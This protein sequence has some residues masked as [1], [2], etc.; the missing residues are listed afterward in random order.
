MPSPQPWIRDGVSSQIMEAYAA[1]MRKRLTT[2]L[3]HSVLCIG[4]VAIPLSIAMAEKAPDAAPPQPDNPAAV[5]PAVEAP[6]SGT[7]ENPYKLIPIRNPFGL[8]APPPPSTDEAPPPPPPPP[9]ITVKLSGLTDL[10]GR[11]IAMLVL[12]ESGPNKT[13]RSRQLGEGEKES[14]VEV[15]AIDFSSRSVK[16]NNNGQVTNVTFGKLE[17]SGA[18]PPPPQ[19]AGGTRVLPNFQ[20]GANQVPPP[21]PGGGSAS[22]NDGNNSSVIIGGQGGGDAGGRGGARGGGVF[23][24]GA[25]PSA[26]VAPVSSSSY[27]SPGSISSPSSAGSYGNTYNGGSVGGGGG[28]AVLPTREPRV[29]SSGQPRTGTPRFQIP[30]PPP[31]PDPSEFSGGTTSGTRQ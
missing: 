24:S 7:P 26:G 22:I 1:Q 15:L 3:R 29:S 12:T 10:L 31:L 23:T 8:A 13:P 21:P 17:A 16:L 5:V 30:M 9:P 2:S 20:N 4:M 18:A 14:G 25:Y 27:S 19:G 11:K 6:A 28:G